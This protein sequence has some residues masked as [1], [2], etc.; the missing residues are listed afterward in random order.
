M[1][2]TA[3]KLNQ[4]VQELLHVKEYLAGGIFPLLVFIK[5]GE[6]STLEVCL[7]TIV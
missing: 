3:P 7:Y 2:K 6:G 1:T 4:R 5:S